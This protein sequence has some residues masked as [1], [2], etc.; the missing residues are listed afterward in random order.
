MTSFAPATTPTHVESVGPHTTKTLRVLT[1]ATFIVILNETIMVNALPVLMEALSIDA[2]AAQWL[3]T[4]F[5]LTMAIVIPTTGWFLQRVGRRTAFVVAMSCFCAGTLLAA[6]APSFQWLLLGRVIQASG[7]AVMMPL[8]LSSVLALVPRSRRGRVMGNVS[9]AIS[10]A[11]AMGPAI[12][13]VVLGFASWRWLFGV[14]L[15]IAVLV[16]VVGAR[17]LRAPSLVA[18]GEDLEPETTVGAL[19]V[20]SVLLTIVGFGGLVYGLSH[21]GGGGEAGMGATSVSATGFLLG[22]PTIALVVGTVGVALF[23]WRQTRLQ[24]RSTPLLDLRVLRHGAYSLSV[25]IMALAFMGLMGAMIMLP[26]YFQEVRG[27]TTLQAGLMLMPGGLTMGALGPVVGRLYDRVGPAPLVIPGA[28]TLA[29][30]LG[31]L[32]WS[33]AHGPWWLFLVLHIGMSVALAFIFTPVFT[34]GLSALPPHLYSHG[35]AL[36]GTLQQVAAAV[37]T[38][39]VITVMSVRTASLVAAG[40]SPSESLGAGIQAGLLVATGLAVA[41]AALSVL[42]LRV[43]RTAA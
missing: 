23:A 13:G 17:M 31:L 25:S 1:V 36:L 21:I 24:R 2:R 39:A 33:T 3:S 22:L 43:G 15:P 14:V 12:S 34:T 10:V 4:G 35:S 37:G 6:L 40:G 5:M 41:V 19:D 28:V 18:K 8:L 42:F 7:T 38:A 11:P 20:P 16:G 30:G 27:M 29:C 26:M 9:L 32:S